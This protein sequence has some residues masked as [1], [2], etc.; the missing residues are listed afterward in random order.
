METHF[1]SGLMKVKDN[2][3]KLSSF[4]LNKGE[5]IRFWEDKWIGN[6]AFKDKYPSLY[7]IVRKMIDTIASVLGI[8]PLNIA[9]RRNLDVSNRI[10][11]NELVQSIVHVWLTNDEDLIRWNLH[12]NGHFTV[13]SMYL[14]L[15]NNGVVERNQYI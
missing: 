4:K 1:W 12:Q 13:H 8:V 2:F 6:V 11:W 10:R 5:Q 14:A 7:N 15:I 3:L 9:F